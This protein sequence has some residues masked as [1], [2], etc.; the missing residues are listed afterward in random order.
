[1]PLRETMVPVT[2]AFLPLGI[3]LGGVDAY[4][5][6]AIS[7][8]QATADNTLT[9]TKSSKICGGCCIFYRGLNPANAGMARR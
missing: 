9:F 1:M 8:T 6:L 7:M 2:L 3:C 4:I 5:R